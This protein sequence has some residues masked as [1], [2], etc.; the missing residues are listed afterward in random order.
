MRISVFGATGMA[1]TPIVA[2]ALNRGHTVTAWSRTLGHFPR[3]QRLTT[4]TIDLSTPRTLARVLD[5]ADAAVLAVRPAPGHEHQI[6]PWTAGF[7]DT[8]A[9]SGTRVLIVGGAAALASPTRSDVLLLDDPDYVPAA[10]R[11]VAQASVD[12]LLACQRHPYTNWVYL[13]PAAIFEPGSPT[14]SYERGT[15][16]L[17]VDTEGVS[18]ITP[19]DLALAVIDELESP[20]DEQHF[21]VAQHSHP[22]PNHESSPPLAVRAGHHN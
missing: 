1:G 8:A 21:T 10:W 2:E 4:G 14:G 18:R 19:P 3:Q 17:I 9:Q 5:A 12:Q 20:S 15:T 13:S 6:A 7:L 16:Q 11:T 22:S